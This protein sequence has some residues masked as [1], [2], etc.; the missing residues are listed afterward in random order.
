MSIV[1]KKV[2]DLF[3]QLDLSDKI[4]RDHLYDINNSVEK[5]MEWKAH[6]LATINQDKQKVMSWI[7]LIQKQHSLF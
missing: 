3:S 6:I 1:L 2:A 7:V 5:I 4:K